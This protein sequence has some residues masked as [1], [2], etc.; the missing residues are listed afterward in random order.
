MRYIKIMGNNQRPKKQKTVVVKTEPKNDLE[1]TGINSKFEN[2]YLNLK[3]IGNNINENA[4]YNWTIT[5]D[6]E[7]INPS[8]I[9]S[10]LI[11]SKVNTVKYIKSNKTT[12]SVKSGS[13]TSSKFEI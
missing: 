13:Y 7:V 8:S 10:I 12:V 5:F 9:G 1:I 6:N 2:E 11:L 3:L 4:N